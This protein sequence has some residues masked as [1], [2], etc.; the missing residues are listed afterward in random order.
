MGKSKLF[1]QVILSGVL[2]AAVAWIIHML[3]AM[4]SMAYYKMPEYASV[5]SKLMMPVAGASPPASFS[6]YSLLF[7]F[8]GGI[9]VAIVYDVLI[10]GIPGKKVNKGLAYGFVL[11]LIAGIPGYLSTVLLIN[12]P[13]GLAAMWLLE[14]LVVYLLGGMVIA[15]IV[16][17]TKGGV[18]KEPAK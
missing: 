1:W 16:R 11:F 13:S 4:L 12:I 3:G 18:K 17:E 2:F 10:G 7:S 14:N 9:L 5:W 8:I 6:W 15:G